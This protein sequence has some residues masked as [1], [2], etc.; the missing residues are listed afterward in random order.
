[1]QVFGDGLVEPVG[2]KSYDTENKARQVAKELAAERGLYA[3]RPE[4]RWT[5]LYLR[6]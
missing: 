5:V 3:F 1:M 4:H 6:K 2:L